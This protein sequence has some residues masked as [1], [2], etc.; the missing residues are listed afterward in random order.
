MDRDDADAQDVKLLS[1]ED[2]RTGLSADTIRRAILENL[3]FIQARGPLLATKN[4]WY[5][6]LAYTVRDRMLENWV[7]STEGLRRD[8]QSAISFGSVSAW[9]PSSW[10][11]F[12]PRASPCAPR[13]WRGWSPRPGVAVGVEPVFCPPRRWRR[14]RVSWPSSA[15][16]AGPGI[17]SAGTIR[18]ST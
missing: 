7:R 10:F 1:K 4:D 12:E 3:K 16:S 11:C 13:C 2:V 5:M 15:G 17:R 14:W 9:L 8:G 6:A 18:A